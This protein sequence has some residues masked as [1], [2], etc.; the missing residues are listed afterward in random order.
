VL[1]VLREGFTRDEIQEA[2]GRFGSSL[3]D[4]RTIIQAIE[5]TRQERRDIL[6]RNNAQNNQGV[7]IA[8]VSPQEDED[9]TM[10]EPE[11]RPQQTS[12]PPSEDTSVKTL[13]APS[14]QR[15]TS[16]SSLTSN[17]SASNKAGTPESGSEDVESI[18]L[19][20]MSLKDKTLCKI[21]MDNPLQMV[22]LPCG[23]LSTCE[24]CS[25]NLKECPICRQNI[26]GKVKTYWS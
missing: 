25:K 7:D 12:S 22:F 17:S 8:P 18:K 10:G 6:A 23:H 5:R 3:V 4:A 2:L 13:P 21:C 20:N 26:T 19:E 1:A 9:V 11:E 14:P 15:S 16:Y 24:D